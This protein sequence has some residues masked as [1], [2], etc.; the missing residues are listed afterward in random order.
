MG[1]GIFALTNAGVNAY[2]DIAYEFTSPVLSLSKFQGAYNDESIIYFDVYDEWQGETYSIDGSANL[3]AG[4]TATDLTDTTYSS[5]NS[6]KAYSDGSNLYV[7]CAEKITMPRDVS[8]MF[9]GYNQ[10]TAVYFNA[11]NTAAVTNMTALFQNCSALTSLNLSSFNTAAVT[12]M[13]YMFSGCTNLQNLD[14]SSFNTEKVIFMFSLFGNCSSLTTLDLTNFD[15]RNVTTMAQMFT[16][17]ASLPELDLS[18][19]NTSNVE[20]MSYMFRGCVSL[21]SIYVS[22]LWSTEAVTTSSDMFTN[23]T[24]LV[25]AISYDATKDDHTYATTDGYLTLV[26]TLSVETFKDIYNNETAIYFDFY[27]SDSTY[28][29]NGSVNLIA[30]LTGVD[31]SGNADGSV[32][33]YSNGSALYV[34]SDAIIKLPASA[35]SMFG[36]YNL[37]ETIQFN[38][39]NTAD[40]T[41][42][43]AMFTGCQRLTSVDL[44]S[45]A[46]SKVTDMSFMFNSCKTLTSLDLSA[47]DTSNVIDMRCM[48]Q[49]CSGLKNIDVSSFSTSKVKYMNNMFYTCNGLS[50]LD[51]SSFDTSSVDNM[52]GMF[53]S[54]SSLTTIYVSNLW[55]TTSVTSSASMFASCTKLVGAVSYDSTKVDHTYATTEY[56][57]TL[58]NS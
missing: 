13:N 44:S 4:L 46:T 47:F 5:D 55:S 45:F 43:S 37:L 53:A 10:L 12:H 57:L 24:N 1:M 36:G 56:Y 22:N 54:C 34:L 41:N 29:N 8:E 49:S 17:C 15:T 19:F 32:L 40:V 30:G 48:F 28:L 26:E 25:G 20:A 50:T 51:L 7:L 14:V 39:I 31:V 27:D 6:I 58:K 52:K 42:M 2:L 18:S 11:V 33:A 16:G 21:A 23:C 35:D 9:Y 3:I 38:N